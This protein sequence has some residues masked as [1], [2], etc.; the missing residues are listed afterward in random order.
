MRL[1]VGR[2][3]LGAAVSAIY[4][5]AAWAEPVQLDRASVGAKVCSW[6]GLGGKVS[7]GLRTDILDAALDQARKAAQTDPS[8]AEGV[9]LLEGIQLRGSYDVTTG[10]VLVDV[11]ASEPASSSVRQSGF[12]QVKHGIYQMVAG[13]F[14]SLDGH[15]ASIFPPGPQLTA[16]PVDGLLVV[17]LPAGAATAELGL[18][19][20]TL[21]PTTLTLPVQGGA[22][23]LDY[24]GWQ[25][26]PGRDCAWL[27]R[28]E[29]TTTGGP[30]S[31]MTIAY[32][33][34][35]KERFLRSVDLTVGGQ[36][37]GR[38]EL[39]EPKVE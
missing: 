12:E 28:I 17:Q 9:R 30:H 16:N 20:A 29:T 6:S 32:Q 13:A 1:L 18:D 25:P 7:F 19:P 10:V 15:R 27:T 33:D 3:G 4:A 21:L 35:G 37:G 2:V 5:G 39:L 23:R 36:H 14:Q 31:V 38:I 24:T 22:I 11:T 8:A 26:D 34:L